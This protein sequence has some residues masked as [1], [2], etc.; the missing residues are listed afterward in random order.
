MYP[1]LAP[2][3]LNLYSITRT[4]QHFVII[5]IPFNTSPGI[6]ICMKGSHLCQCRHGETQHC[7]NEASDPQMEGP[8]CSHDG[9]QTMLH[10][11]KEM[12]RVVVG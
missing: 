2:A 3:V 12:P 8:G 1:R 10:Q 4:Q 6:K 9:C 5:G 7:W 11:R